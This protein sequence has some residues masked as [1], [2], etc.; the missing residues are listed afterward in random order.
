[1]ARFDWGGRVNELFRR[2]KWDEAR[3][4]LEKQREQEPANHWLLTQLGVTFYEQKRYKEALKLF[5]A[6]RRILDDCP[7]TLWNLAGTLDALGEYEDA[8][9]IYVWLL[10]SKR[11]PQEDPCWE[12]PEWAN[13]LK[14]DCVYRLGVCFQNLGKEQW[15]EHCYRQY[16]VLLT[17][18]IDGTYSAADVVRRI[19]ELHGSGSRNSAGNAIRKAFQSTLRIAGVE[20]AKGRGS[21]SPQ[22]AEQESRVGQRVGSKK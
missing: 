19:R 22:F 11:T 2:S 14:T 4:L 1:M 8:V 18:G 21:K 20:R 15:A 3:A 6:S 16:L 9:R 12:S 5:R 17:L 7:L 13:S 10:G